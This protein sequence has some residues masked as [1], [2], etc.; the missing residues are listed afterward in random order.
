[1]GV[2]CLQASFSGG[3]VSPAVQARID[4][5]AYSSWLKTAR[6]FLFIRRAGRLTARALYLWDRPNTRINPAA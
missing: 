5:P 2:H 4:S 1:M 6:N 3:E